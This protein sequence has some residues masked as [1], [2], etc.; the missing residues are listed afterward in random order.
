M[1]VDTFRVNAPVVKVG[2]GVWVDARWERERGADDAVFAFGDELGF[3]FEAVDLPGTEEEGGDGDDGCLR[4]G[5]G[6]AKFG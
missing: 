1:A 4:V 6:L 3:P 5:I 2:D